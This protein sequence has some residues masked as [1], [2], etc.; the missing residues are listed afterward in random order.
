MLAN[1]ASKFKQHDDE[2]EEIFK[3][4]V[5]LPR[6]PEKP[7]VRA[8]SP[9][10]HAPVKMDHLHRRRSPSPTKATNPMQ[11]V[12]PRVG[13][14]V[15]SASVAPASPVKTT[16]ES[17]PTGGFKSILATKASV[18]VAS[19]SS[20]IKNTTPTGYRAPSPTKQ[21]PTFRSVSPA[22]VL[23]EQRAGS[24]TKLKDQAFITSLKAQGFEE[25]SSKSKLV[26]NFEKKDEKEEERSNYA[27]NFFLKNDEGSKSGRDTVGRRKESSKEMVE[28]EEDEEV[29]RKRDQLSPMRDNMVGGKPRERSP[30][31]VKTNIFLARDQARRSVRG[32]E[33]RGRSTRR[34]SPSKPVP[35]RQ[36]SPSK[37]AGQIAK[38]SFGPSVP[39][40]TPAGPPKP[41]RTFQATPAADSREEHPTDTLQSK[42]IL[43]KR[44]MF[45][46]PQ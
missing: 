8:P 12:S 28:D 4:E 42:S 6:S 33:D 43:Q 9:T 15:K 46:G 21:G 22:K 35:I 34:V 26:Y 16:T 2:E 3:E 19:N 31:P 32:D 13:S 17:T 11:F 36:P 27:D 41:S 40:T 44:S 18:T 1:L 38:P 29:E 20:P 23:V 37:A 39:S 7:P 5:K 45:E 30:S 25:T 14:P 10:K 24:P